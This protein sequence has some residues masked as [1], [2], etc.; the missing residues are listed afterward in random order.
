[1]KKYNFSHKTDSFEH[2]INV[3]TS[4]KGNHHVALFDEQGLGKT[5]MV[6]AG[7]VEDIKNKLI[8]CVLVVCKK[9][10][11]KTWENEIE[12]H[13]HL[14]SVNLTGNL[15]ERKKYFTTFAH[16]YLINYES[17]IQE[18]E[19]ISEL[20]QLKQFAIVLDESH[21]IKNPD[22]KITKSI[23]RV[24]KY[25]KKNIIITGTPVANKP[26]DLWA[27]FYFLDNGKLLGNDFKNFKKEYGVNISMGKNKIK[28]DNLKKLQKK[29]KEF[30]IRRTKDVAAPDI[31]SKEF[32]EEFVELRGKQK[33]MYDSLKEKLYIEIKNM[34]GKIIQDE[35]KNILKKL[36]RL[37]QIASNPLLIDLNYNEEPVKFKIL[38]S[39]IKK[40]INRNEKV[41][42]WTSFVGNIILLKKRYRKYNSLTLFG[43]MKIKDRNKVVKWFQEDPDYKVLIANPSAAKEGLTLT[44]ANNAIYLDRTFNVVDYLQ[45][46]D[47][48]HRISQKKQSNI[49]LIIAKNTV[50]EYIE[51]L[52]MKKQEIARLIQGDIDDINYPKPLLT[53]DSLLNILGEYSSRWQKKN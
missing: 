32:F 50:D 40:I 21:K 48:I 44:A 49:F 17:L 47:R 1:M 37:T 35:S 19:L 46:Q 28:K 3:I 11:L 45:S 30:A 52:L 12:F 33:K 4:I 36:L 8:D 38:D 10:L 24:K 53:K 23:M 22:S 42:V 41:I 31:P 7:L 15:N 13:C 34:D 39:L 29:I 51:E 14:R 26:E 2:Q 43:Q 20:L 27:Q 25:S 16:F 9:T 5:K 18:E 6:I